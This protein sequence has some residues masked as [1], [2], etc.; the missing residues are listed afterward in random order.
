MITKYK[1]IHFEKNP[2]GSWS[3]INNNSNKR[4]ALIDWYVPLGKYVV[5]DFES[6]YVFSSD[7]LTDIADFLN[8]LKS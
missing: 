7:C 5:I 3:C 1:R 8:Q 6:E 4:L 2:N